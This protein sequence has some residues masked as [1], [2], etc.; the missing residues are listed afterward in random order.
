LG[1]QELQRTKPVTS[2][3]ILQP[4]YIPWRGHFHQIQKA[5]VF[6]F[7]D[8]VQYDRGGWRN[9]NR[10][11]T[12]NGSVWLTIPVAKKGSVETGA[13]IN[14]IRIDWNRAW[15]K[16]HWT[17]IRQS[18]A[19]APFF[20]TYRGVLEDIYS[21]RPE[22]LVDF[23]IQT[24]IEIAGLLGLAN[25]RY[26]RSSQLKAGG[27]KTDRLVSI[28][29]QVGATHYISGPS[30]RNYLEEEKLADAGISLEYMAYEYQPYR[31]LHPPF[32]P[33]VSIID[34]LMMTGPK[35]PRFIWGDGEPV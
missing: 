9:R 15:T 29:Q 5:D 34:L 1:E 11:K 12:P 23:T 28:L 6:V 19:K 14:S 8:D 4:S 3:V 21:R 7:Y 31:Q 10:V 18:Y 13:P 27:V 26:L 17:T 20:E 35:A 25:K 22:M 16:V 2:C 33:Q 30:A 32:D 24:T